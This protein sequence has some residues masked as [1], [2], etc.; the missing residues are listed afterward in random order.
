MPSRKPVENQRIISHPWCKS[1]IVR[2]AI[3]CLVLFA[4]LLMIP[5]IKI[6]G[7][8]RVIIGALSLVIGYRFLREW[9]PLLGPFRRWLVRRLVRV[10][11][12]LRPIGKLPADV[13]VAY[14]MV[15]LISIALTFVNWV[16]GIE[17]EGS[18]YI[19]A[20]TIALLAYAVARHA[21][22][23]L[24]LIAGW[25]W[26]K[27][28]W[29]AIY[30]AVASVA[31]WLSRADAAKVILLL[32]NETPEHFSNFAGMLASG[33]FVLRLIQALAFVLFA[34]S[35]LQFAFLLFNML[36][37]HLA[38]NFSILS[39]TH[40]ERLACFW[41]RLRTG[42]KSKVPAKAEWLRDCIAML[43]PIGLLI[44][45][46]L[47]LFGPALLMRN[48]STTA[49]LSNLLVRIEY[50]HAGA[51]H[52]ISSQGLFARVNDDRV[53]QAVKEGDGYT[54]RTVACKKAE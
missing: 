28:L 4:L 22:H 6:R 18:D 41:R 31:L 19:A 7:A 26:S 11:R 38:I 20:A 1:P 50:S 34:F 37:Q 54:F 47:L 33:F 15:G 43:A 12:A 14:G 16:L 32:T 3:V 13:P 17:I 40:V 5:L 29:K 53:S 49:L 23:V 45:A 8:D 21:Y 2:T 25:T 35:M 9:I 30:L 44:W 52:G 51:C 27:V 36:T 48:P 46:L 24:R 39:K 10:M 42:E